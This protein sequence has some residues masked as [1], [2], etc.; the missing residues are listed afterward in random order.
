LTS[1]VVVRPF[2]RPDL[3]RVLK[4]EQASFAED[5]WDSALFL[6]YFIT[7]P[8]LFLVATLARRIAGYCITSAGSRSAELAS[9]AVNTRDRGQGVGQNLLEHTLQELRRRRIRTC[10]LMVATVN[11]DA[12]RFY[13]RHGFTRTRL[14]KNYYRAGR[15]A[16]RMQLAL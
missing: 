6:R 9:I 7:S 5:A 13:Q 3:E 12:Q 8:D 14:V 1:R 2:Q 10:W 11:E 4:I 16:W 15:D